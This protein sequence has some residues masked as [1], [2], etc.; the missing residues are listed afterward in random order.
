MRM[1]AKTRLPRL[2]IASAN[3]VALVALVTL[4]ALAPAQQKRPADVADRIARV[5]KGLMR[6]S[7]I[8]GQPQERYTIE[9]RLKTYRTPGVSV[10][11]MH[12]G[13]IEWAKGYGVVRAGTTESVDSATLFQAASISKPVAAVTALKL[14]EKG[15][16]TLDA[17][18]NTVLKSWKVPDNS[19]TATEKVTLRRLL[20]HSA[21][22][23]VHGFPGYAADSTVPTVVQ[24]LDGTRPANTAAVRV[25]VAPGSIWRYSGGGFTVM[26]LA[27]SDLTGK[28]FPEL[29]RELVLGPAGMTSSGY[30]QP[31]PEAKRARAAIAHRGNGTV[32]TGLWHT[33]PEMAAAGLWTTPT[34][35]LLFARAI[36]RSLG[37][38]ANALLSQQMARDFVTVQKGTYGLGVSVEGTGATARFS[39][40]GANEG[41]RCMFFAFNERGDGVAIMTNS[42][43]GGQVASEIAR[44]VSDVYGWAVMQPTA[45]Q[46]ITVDPAQLKSI[47]GRYLLA[48][49]TDTLPVVMRF[50][51]GVLFAEVLP[52]GPRPMR[53]YASEPNRFFTLE[54]GAEFA[55]DRDASG[56]VNAIRLLN[57]GQP[58][59]AVRQP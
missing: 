54:S 18:I 33:Y 37:G 32:V 6:P 31:L 45:R 41:Y 48:T 14:V 9:E 58:L 12:N 46:A 26:Q 5:E 44:A 4:P 38:E 40:G 1:P 7:Y 23:T 29:A 11:V 59:R 43:N 15:R 56:A 21:G 42:D 2:P 10:A 22:L 34:D 39:H 35:L 16:L 57:L 36:Q 8:A 20:S 27:I 30:E 52:L 25:N 50:D 19:F 28:T 51:D 49:P 3:L 17:D 13:K 47:A 24:I 53:L 55:I